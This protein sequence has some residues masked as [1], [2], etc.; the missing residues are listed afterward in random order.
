MPL[1]PHHA[2]RTDVSL[3]E[4]RPLRFAELVRY[5][6]GLP[7]EAAA[8]ADDLHRATV[9]QPVVAAVAD[10]LVRSHA[11]VPDRLLVAP[12]ADGLCRNARRDRSPEEELAR[13]PERPLVFHVLDQ[14]PL[15]KNQA[16]VFVVPAA[17]LAK[18]AAQL[19]VTE[20]LLDVLLREASRN[21]RLV[22]PH[23]KLLRSAELLVTHQSTAKAAAV[24]V[25]AVLLANQ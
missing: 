22:V 7:V 11:P 1:H 12:R 18:E 4:R 23:Q 21:V 19:L 6:E 10:P 8:V 20:V 17:L 13:L 5:P 25:A 9:D 24:A 16:V 3:Q 2:T 14:C 15:P